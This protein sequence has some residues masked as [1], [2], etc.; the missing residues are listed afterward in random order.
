MLGL[1]AEASFGV[2][3]NKSK[4]WHILM[5]LGGGVH[6]IEVEIGVSFDELPTRN[7][8]VIDWR[9]CLAVA[10]RRLLRSTDNPRCGVA[11][12]PLAHRSHG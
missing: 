12:G 3:S 2:C 4:Q 10:L 11:L 5:P 9:R 1:F 7:W 8:L 6:S